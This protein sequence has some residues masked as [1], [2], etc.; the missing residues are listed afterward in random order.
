MARPPGTSYR[1]LE[2]SA[3][4]KTCALT[5]SN[6]GISERFL[7]PTSAVLSI[8]LLI[9]KNKEKKKRKLKNQFSPS[10]RSFL[11][12]RLYIQLVESED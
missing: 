10:S 2:C 5:F 8:S 11:S 12:L 4:L 9:K 7:R 6:L 3:M 1:S